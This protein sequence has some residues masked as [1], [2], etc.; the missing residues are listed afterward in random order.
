[1]I[2]VIIP[3]LNSEADLAHTLAAL[4]PAAADGVVREVIVVDGGSSDNTDQVADAAGCTWITV[5]GPRSRRLIAG[6]S[7]SERGEW[8]LFLNPDTVLETGWHHDVQAFIERAERAGSARR[9]AA[10]FKL[11][12]E[13]F[14]LA[15]R[16]WE[17]WSTLRTRLLGMPYADQGLLLTRHFYQELGGHRALPNLEDLDLVRRIGARR[18]VSLRKAA[19]SPERSRQ[20]GRLRAI[21]RAIARFCIGT[22]RLPASLVLK[23]HG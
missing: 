12:Y 13:A 4:V 8:L 18:V 3:T 22:L 1:M 17:G 7:A 16:L 6:A 9:I 5:A 15:P 21:R 10:A 23:L 14:G 11:R 2:S 19:I 20:E